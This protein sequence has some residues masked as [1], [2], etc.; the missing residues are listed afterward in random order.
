MKTAEL[1]EKLKA[2]ICV[3]EIVPGEYSLIDL[4]IDTVEEIVR[5][6][7]SK[8]ALVVALKDTRYALKMLDGNPMNCTAY[9]KHAERALAA[10][11]AL[12]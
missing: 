3:A 11:E 5:H 6:L 10:E 12:S 4:P 7:E 2:E 1:I 8:E 9:I